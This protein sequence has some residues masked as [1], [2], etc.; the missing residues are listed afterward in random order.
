MSNAPVGLIGVCR[1]QSIVDTG[2]HLLENPGDILLE[3]LLVTDLVDQCLRGNNDYT[4]A[5]KTQAID[6]LLLV[7]VTRSQGVALGTQERAYTVFVCHVEHGSEGELRVDIIDVPQKRQPWGLW[8]GHCVV[9]H[10]VL[11]LGK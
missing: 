2:P 11:C 6:F 10:F 4:S 8:N 1:E 7:S 9:R 3:A 5:G